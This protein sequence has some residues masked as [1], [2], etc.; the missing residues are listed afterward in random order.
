MQAAMNNIDWDWVRVTMNEANWHSAVHCKNDLIDL[1]WEAHDDLIE[2][3]L[4]YIQHYTHKAQLWTSQ[5]KQN[6]N[7]NILF[8]R[9]IIVTECTSCNESLDMLYKRLI[10]EFLTSWHDEYS[11]MSCRQSSE[12]SWDKSNWASQM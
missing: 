7:M 1:D 3:K 12:I 10:E 11:F 6:R 5:T 2:Q 4:L 9:K 8:E